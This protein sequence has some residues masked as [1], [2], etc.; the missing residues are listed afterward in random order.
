MNVAQISADV[1]T[2]AIG[3]EMSDTKAQVINVFDDWC[4]ENKENRVADYR[5]HV[6]KFLRLA[7]YDISEIDRNFLKKIWK[8]KN[9][10]ER[11]INPLTAWNNF[12]K[13]GAT[14]N[15]AI[16]PA[17]CIIEKTHLIKDKLPPAMKQEIQ[18]IIET[19]IVRSTCA[20]LRKQ[21]QDKIHQ[22]FEA[23]RHFVLS[24]E[25]SRNINSIGDF[26]ENDAINFTNHLY[27]SE[28][29][30]FTG[31]KVKINSLSAILGDIKR[32]YKM[33]ITQRKLQVNI[34]E[35][36]PI[37]MFK[38]PKREFCLSIKQIEKLRT[39]DIDK[40]D[41]MTLEK[42]FEQIRNNT[43]ISAQYEPA[44]RG[45]DVVTLCWEDLPK[46]E[47]SSSNVGPVVIR[48]GKQR[49]DTHEDRIYIPLDRLDADLY[50]WK[51]I[52]DEYCRVKKIKPPTIIVDGKEYHPIFFSSLGK[53]L[54]P[55][56]YIHIFTKQLK[57]TK[58]TLPKGYKTH[59]IRHSRITHWVDE[60]FP[61]EKVHENARHS[62][63]KQTWDYFHSNPKKRI[64]AVEKVY[65]L[66]QKLTT[67]L[68]PQSGILRKIIEL[69]IS[70]LKFYENDKNIP[71]KVIL[72]EVINFVKE[73]CIDHVP[74]DL[75]YTFREV[76][77]KLNLSRNQTYERLKILKKKE[78]ITI[79]ESKNGKKLYLKS[80]IDY[81][82]SL[83]NSRKASVVFGYKE[84]V[85]TTIPG[86]VQKGMIKSLKVGKLH[87]FEPQELIGYFYTKNSKSAP[88]SCPIS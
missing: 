14:V 70:A 76:M 41:D 32:I 88:E 87:Y 78:I 43:M 19:H 77:E 65:G 47:R 52:A 11:Y 61:F 5:N 42:K 26:T 73:K 30:P 36:I 7:N 85:P 22:S 63:L 2:I 25:V 68:L 20:K 37:H 40:L 9:W 56:S 15:P 79:F 29:S 51:Q 59:I 71:N 82:S 74:A 1:R 45:D 67:S 33:G 23:F 4:R 39:C 84:K 18:G 38:I 21:S 66:N 12:C 10:S 31:K 44:L 16:F 46:H 48:G 27:T 3:K 13:F 62:D 17:N 60:G 72:S 8:R 6:K 86:L 64:E 83:L 28:K 75:F 34:F 53:Q 50:R 54:S 49:Q 57:K 24:S 55:A 81:L 80:E 35:K 69:V 58:I